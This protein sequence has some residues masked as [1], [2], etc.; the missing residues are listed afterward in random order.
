MTVSYRV[1]HVVLGLFLGIN[2]CGL[3]LIAREE[4]WF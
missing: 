4:G 1:L 3:I 2:I